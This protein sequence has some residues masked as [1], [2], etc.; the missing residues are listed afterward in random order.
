MSTVLTFQCFQAV[1]SLLGEYLE[2]G[3]VVMRLFISLP[4]C[5]GHCSASGSKVIG[6]TTCIHTDS[7]NVLQH[8]TNML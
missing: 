3:G 6:C 2:R 8:W 5:R 7:G 1:I 4:L